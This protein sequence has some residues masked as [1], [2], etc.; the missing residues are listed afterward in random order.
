MHKFKIGES[1]IIKYG[2]EKGKTAIIK[3]LQKG[4]VYKITIDNKTGYYSEMS[5]I[6]VDQ[7]IN[8][9]KE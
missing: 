7:N 9:E 4:L 3:E 6:P 8:K 2:T 5:L 1:V